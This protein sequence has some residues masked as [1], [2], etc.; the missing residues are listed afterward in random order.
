MAAEE[1]GND[2]DLIRHV[3]SLTEWEYLMLEADDKL[4]VVDFNAT[5]YVCSI[6]AE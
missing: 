1:A 4:V 5:W 2:D 6:H 3:G